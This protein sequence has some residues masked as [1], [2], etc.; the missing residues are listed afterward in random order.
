[1]PIRRVEPDT[2][3]SRGEAPARGVAAPAPA[4]PASARA[5]APPVHGAEQMLDA[6][7]PPGMAG[8]ASA[9]AFSGEG[10]G[11]AE[12]IAALE[13][14]ARGLGRPGRDVLARIGARLLRDEAAS[15]RA[16]EAARGAAGS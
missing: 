15:A 5:A 13:R 16:L 10:F 6:I 9:G 1:M 4:A 12:M 7:A 11:G 3:P 14:A 8:S 2:E